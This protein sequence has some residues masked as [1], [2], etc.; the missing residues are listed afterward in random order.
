MPCQVKC[1]SIVLV[2]HLLTNYVTHTH[3]LTGLIL[4]G[5]LSSPIR[6]ANGNAA[7]EFLFPRAAKSDKNAAGTFLNSIVKEGM[8]RIEPSIPS[9]K[10]QGKCIR[11]GA[12]GELILHNALQNDL[13]PGWL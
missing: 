7:N 8:S 3:S 6:A 13:L 9:S 5:C 1:F 4:L 11:R 10:C 12:L 2:S